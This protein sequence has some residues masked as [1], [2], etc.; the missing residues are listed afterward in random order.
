MELGNPYEVVVHYLL[1][2]RMICLGH[3]D[4]IPMVTILVCMVAHW[5]IPMVS[6][7]IGYWIVMTL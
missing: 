1:I 4:E 7:D 6:H 2:R 3:K 5:T